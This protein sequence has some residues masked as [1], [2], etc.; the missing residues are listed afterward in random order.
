M[1]QHLSFEDGVLVCIQIV[2]DAETRDEALRRLQYLCD[3]YDVVDQEIR[4]EK[5]KEQLGLWGIL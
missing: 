4:V 5:V 2:E 3:A 1:N